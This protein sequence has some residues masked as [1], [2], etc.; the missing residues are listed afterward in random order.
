M[1]ILCINRNTVQFK[2]CNHLE[3]EKSICHVLH[4]ACLHVELLNSDQNIS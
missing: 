1:F 2:Y 3:D 4:C